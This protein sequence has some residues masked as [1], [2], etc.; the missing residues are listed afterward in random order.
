[1]LLDY[2]TTSN[3]NNNNGWIHLD[4]NL[5]KT[6]IDNN[7]LIPVRNLIDRLISWFYY[8]KHLQIVKQTRYSQSLN[9]LIDPTKCN[10]KSIQELIRYVTADT[11]EASS[12]T[13]GMMSDPLNNHTATTT[14]PNYYFQK[15]SQECLKGDILYYGHI[16]FNYKYY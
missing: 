3:N 10:I 6:Q 2:E 13:I 9:K 16:F 5:Y 8:G 7:F 11:T 15:L 4:R 12:S 1:M 14:A